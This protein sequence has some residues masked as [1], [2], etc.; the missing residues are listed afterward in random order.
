MSSYLPERCGIAKYA[1]QLAE[2]LRRQ[3][4]VVN[5]LA[6]PGSMSDFCEPLKGKLGP[7]KVLKYAFFYDK[8]LLNFHESFFYQSGVLNRA[9]THL[10]FALLFLLA[11][12]LEVICH[13]YPKLEGRGLLG[14]LDRKVLKLIWS[15]APRVVFHT[16]R[17]LSGFSKLFGVPRE[18]LGLRRHGESFMRFAAAGKLE[19]RRKLSLSP[20]DFILLCIG[21]IQP[22]K[23]FDRVV[24][25][26]KKVKSSR[27][28]LYIVGSIRLFTREYIEYLR[29]LR[30]LASECSG[31]HLV[32]RYISDEEFDLWIASSDVVVLPY[33]EIWS[34]GVL[35]RAKLYGK[36]VIASDV[37]GVADQLSSSDYLFKSDEEL[38]ELLQ[39][40][41]E[42]ADEA[43][44]R[45]EDRDSTV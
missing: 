4:H 13:E 34:S 16:E 21:F 12:N 29:E 26:F 31:V 9:F 35:E 24:K 40:L 39:E 43:L 17:E 42:L 10:S 8:V 30:R 25:A 5:V 6:P 23:G 15:L 28:K 18:R 22:H 3:G 32:Y 19:A 7:L 36:P 41:A 27:V 2:H 33:R 38:E 45:R 11:R 1:W 14:W 37:G 44:S 20:S